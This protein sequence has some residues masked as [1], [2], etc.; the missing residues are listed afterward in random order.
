[1][2][3]A[4]LGNRQKPRGGRWV[5]SEEGLWEAFHSSVQRR[6]PFFC[7][8]HIAVAFPGVV[9]VPS[10]AGPSQLL[11][12]SPPSL[13]RPQRELADGSSSKNLSSFVGLP[14]G[15]TAP[16]VM[17][18]R[19]ERPRSRVLNINPGPP[20]AVCFESPKTGAE[21]TVSQGRDGGEVSYLI[22]FE[23]EGPEKKA[24]AEGFRGRKRK[25]PFL[26]LPHYLMTQ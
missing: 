8:F 5:C 12:P 24:Q 2:T 21:K 6:P 15:P 26:T 19:Q 18:I 9:F 14:L 22:H 7:S 13:Q 3:F 23:G 17:P 1:M 4:M 11:L 16:I 25:K 20:P 10:P